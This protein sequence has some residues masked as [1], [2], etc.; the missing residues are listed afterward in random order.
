MKEYEEIL[1]EY[2]DIREKYEGIPL[3]YRPCE[4]KKFR[5][6]SLYIALGTY[7]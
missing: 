3:L 6:L 5:D 1:G 7:L 4:L 2:E